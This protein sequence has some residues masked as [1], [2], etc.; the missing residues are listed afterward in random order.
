[1]NKN[2]NVKTRENE[3]NPNDTHSLFL[4]I[5]LHDQHESRD[6]LFFQAIGMQNV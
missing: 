2:D 6:I 1:M 5:D 4:K 3:T